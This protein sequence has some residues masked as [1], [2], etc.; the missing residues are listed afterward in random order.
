MR[1]LMFLVAVTIIF[2]VGEANAATCAVGSVASYQGTSCSIDGLNFSGFQGILN[3]SPGLALFSASNITVT[4]VADANGI[5]FVLTPASAADWTTNQSSQTLDLNFAFI[6]GC[7]NGTACINDIFEQLVGSVQATNIGGGTSGVD[8]LT[9][10]YCL[11]SS[12][13]PAGSCGS[14]TAGEQILT[15]TPST[16]GGTAS[17]HPTFSPVS[18]LAMNKDISAQ[19]FNTNTASLISLTDEFS[20]V[21]TPEP[22]ALAMLG[23]GLLGLALFSMRRKSVA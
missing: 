10:T 19:S 1:K 8:T 11:G 23:A 7:A 9:E 2:G 17:S 13:L 3:A 15:V 16:S 12:T 6:V 5:G 21:S 4:P 14:G 18:T 22:S 20:L